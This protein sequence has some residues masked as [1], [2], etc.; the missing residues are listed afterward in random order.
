MLLA[1]CQ[2]AIAA[3]LL[4]WGRLTTPITRGDTDVR[5]ALGSDDAMSAAEAVALLAGEIRAIRSR[6]AAAK[7]LHHLEQLL[8]TPCFAMAR[9]EIGTIGPMRDLALPHWWA[10]GGREWLESQVERIPAMLTAEEVVFPPE[11]APLPSARQMG[12]LA[13]LLC[14]PFDGGCGAE[15]VPWLEATQREFDMTAAAGEPEYY[16]AECAKSAVKF[17]TEQRYKI[18]W[19]CIDGWRRRVPTLPVGRFRVPNTGWIFMRAEEGD[20]GSPG[21]RGL[22]SIVILNLADGAAFSGFGGISSS[23][24][25]N[26]QGSPI[27]VGRIPPRRVREIGLALAIGPSVQ[28]Q[29]RFEVYE[30]PPGVPVAWTPVSTTPPY[31]RTGVSIGTQRSTWKWIDHGALMMEGLFPTNEVR[32]VQGVDATRGRLNS[33]IDAAFVS[34]KAVCVAAPPFSVLASEGRQLSPA[35]LDILRSIE[36]ERRALCAKTKV[37]RPTAPPLSPP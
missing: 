19:A 15:A 30:V 35:D 21:E 37:E 28:N 4:C 26:G 9:Q 17:P 7:G 25:E 1:V 5:C 23:K 10:S 3:L 27:R 29:R 11:P 33:L 13:Y 31:V 24:N 12:G 20:S 14:A 32:D 18:W 16:E 36:A 22:D 34:L 8:K 6:T 2:I